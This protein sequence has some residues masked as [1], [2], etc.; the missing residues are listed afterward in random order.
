MKVKVG[1]YGSYTFDASS[2]TITISGLNTDLTLDQFLLITNVADNV[3]IYNFSDPTKG[4]T[5]SN[6]VLSL[7]Y[8]TSSM[9]DDDPLLIYLDI[10][11]YQRSFDKVESYYSSVQIS[12]RAGTFPIDMHSKVSTEGLATSTG[13]IYSLTATGTVDGLLQVFRASADNVHD[14]IVPV[15]ATG[16]TADVLL[17]DCEYANNVAAEADWVSSNEGDFDVRSEGVTVYSGDY[18]LRIDV[19]NADAL[20]ATA[21]YTYSTNQ[22]WV[23]ILTLKF[24]FQCNQNTGVLRLKIQDASSNI[25]YSDID[26]DNQ[27]VWYLKEVVLAT[28]TNYSAVDKSTIKKIIWECRDISNNPRYFIDDIYLAST[29][30]LS[31]PMDIELYDFGSN[32]LPTTITGAP[33]VLDEYNTYATVNVSDHFAVL[34]AHIH[35]ASHRP[36]ANRKL[37]VGDYYGLYFKKPSYGAINFYGSTLGQQY[38]SGKT[39]L[40][41]SNNITTISGVSLGF[42]VYAYVPGLYKEIRVFLDHTA[43]Y[44]TIFIYKVD[45]NNKFKQLVYN[46]Q[47]LNDIEKVISFSDDFSEQIY[48]D[49]NHSLEAV[50]TDSHISQADKVNVEVKFLYESFPT[51]G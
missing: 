42:L 18:S 9:S 32:S 36:D 24:R 43:E 38:N 40:V 51:Y 30:N 3:I 5:V 10:P 48:I 21:T 8:D 20:N 46:S 37:T 14:I 49:A 6:N 28:M 12:E 2:G 1:E 7:T 22:N 34:N 15:S 26:V 17:F 33:L 45:N 25:M 19:K 41:E 29:E 35:M 23:S 47:F 39:S 31:I 50:Y 27:N 16:Q 4:G 44:S 13:L 11:K